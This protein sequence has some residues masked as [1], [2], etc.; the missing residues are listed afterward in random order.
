MPRG[1]RISTC[2]LRLMSPEEP[3]PPEPGRSLVMPLTYGN[4]A[5]RHRMSH[6]DPV[7]LRILGTQQRSVVSPAWRHQESP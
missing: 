5:A 2:D 1:D 6:D 3:V 7:F 4:A